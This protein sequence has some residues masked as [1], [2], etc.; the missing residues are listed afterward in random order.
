MPGEKEG[1]TAFAKPTTPFK[2]LAK[3]PKVN[4]PFR[5]QRS[6]PFWKRFGWFSGR[7]D[8]VF[9]KAPGV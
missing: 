8:T 7:K 4:P 5:Q 1:E 6:R 3:D 2:M 9:G